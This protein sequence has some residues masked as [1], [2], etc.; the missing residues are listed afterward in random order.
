MYETSVKRSDTGRRDTYL[1][2]FLTLIVVFNVVDI[3]GFYHLKMYY[4][5]IYIYQFKAQLTH[6]SKK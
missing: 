6:I 2:A 3:F 4:I 5:Y 1:T